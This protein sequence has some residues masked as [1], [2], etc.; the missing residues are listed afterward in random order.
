MMKR[1]LFSIALL[2]LFFSF[3]KAQT[4]VQIG[5][6]TESSSMPYT[7][8]SY[9]WAK[10]LYSGDEL[11]GTKTI[12]KI[13]LESGS[14]KTLDNQ[15]IYLKTTTDNALTGTYEDP[16]AN[17]TLVYSGSYSVT[18]GWNEITLDTPFEY[19]GSENLVVYWINEAGSEVYADFKAT[20][21]TEQVIKVKGGDASVPASD[22]FTAYPQ[23]LPN[24]RFHYQSDAPANPGNPQPASNAIKVDVETDLTFDLGNNTTHYDIC[25]GRD[26][27]NLDTIVDNQAATAPT[28]ITH[29]IDTLLKGDTE[30]F[31][32]AIAIKESTGER[33]ASAVW[34]FTTEAAIDQYP[35]S[36]SF[37]EVWEGIGGN[38]LSSII[39]TNYPD[40]TYWDWTEL[41]WN[42]EIDSNNVDGNIH[43]GNFGLH[44]SATS[45]GE[46]FVRTPRFILP[47]NMRVSFW[48]KNSIRNTKTAQN[49]ETYF[50][51]S[52]D[53]G[54]TWNTLDTLAPE[55]TMDTWENALVDLSDYAGNN[56]YLRWVYDVTQTSGNYVF[57]DDVTL[58]EKPEGAVIELEE[59]EHAYQQLCKGGKLDYE[60]VIYNSGISNLDI[61]DANVTGDFEC[62][63]S[64][65]IAAGEKDTAIV[66]F[67]PATSGDHEGTVSF[68]SNGS[69][70]AE[71]ALT[72]TA[73]EPVADFF[74]AFDDSDNL[75]AA[76]NSINSPDGYT[77]GGGV[78]VVSFSGD[79]FS[80]PNAAKI[81]MSNDT[82]SPLLLITPGV[83]NYVENHLTFYA[84]KA[85]KYYDVDMQVGVMSN[86]YDPSTFIPKET[87]SLDTVFRK[88]TVT[89][90]PTTS[91]P[92]IAFK[93]N[94]NP[95]GSDDWTSL[96]ID[97]ISWE[98]DEPAAPLAAENISP[99]ND[100][101]GV[102][103]LNA[104]NLK[105][106]AGSGNTN[107]FK[108]FI[109][110]GSDNWDIVNGDTLAENINEYEITKE[111][112]YSTQY[113]WKVVPFNEV[114]D[115]EDCPVWDF[116]TMEDPMV[117]SFPWSEN[118]DDVENTSGYTMPHGW[119]NQ[120]MND[121]NTTWDLWTDNP[122]AG[123]E[124]SH[125][126]PNA[127]YMGLSLFNPEN[128]YLYSVPFRF[129]SHKE[130]KL[131]FWWASQVDPTTGQVYKERVKIFL[132]DNNVDSAM[133][134]E[135][136]NDS[137]S[138]DI[139]VKDSVIFSPEKSGRQFISFY[140][141]SDPIENYVV[142]IDDLEVTV[143]NTAPVINST[144][145]TAVVQGDE[146]SYA[147]EASDA[148]G[149]DIQIN[150]ESIPGW[151]TLTDNGDGT[152]TLSGEPSEVGTYDITLSSTDGESTYYQEFEITV[153]EKE[154]TGIDH[155]EDSAMSIY[156]NPTSGQIQVQIEDDQQ[157]KNQTIKVSDMTGK[158]VIKTKVEG[159]HTSIDLSDLE[160]GI[161]ILQIGSLKNRVTEKIIL[162]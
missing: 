162:K 133:T 52:A 31:W 57:L 7:S 77:S 92:Y 53:G 25:F 32:Q 38:V 151:L 155:W 61:T 104:L 136:F 34:N 71:I 65:S 119:S 28:T 35:W 139:Y 70:N 132:G 98:L 20:T 21:T 150:A 145:D 63:Y 6:G 102:D 93:H 19:N 16:S 26:E 43:S 99:A 109:G 137:I 75:P 135:L 76:W 146:Y 18:S 142:T 1:L 95:N 36:T 29:T 156:P 120:D 149:D 72:G 134:T 130:Y 161:Y 60:L 2:A 108:L 66:S 13:S 45:E 124:Y 74:Q 87:I 85:D 147:I 125:S 89:F 81:L 86:P 83:K 49:D 115:A 9:S 157:H 39:N 154:S 17:Y 152:A 96:R 3:S 4:Y 33:Q 113:F 5:E 73:V 112:K 159:T 110:S 129:E 56:V 158:V 48:W 88:D 128:D 78:D 79:Y 59:T 106:S 148:D 94:G 122:E 40:S 55:S 118:F 143:T 22:G 116:T 131:S 69:G 15:K 111:L 8:W 121:D 127:M 140:A 114:G 144:P 30:Y 50:Q 23:A 103:I 27:N 64:G 97:N 58:E 68:N 126:A 44:C 117:T 37:E 11:G 101:M 141:W 14:A 62:N 47:E 46:S 24:I 12:T 84:K 41:S 10:A 54:Q 42:L 80:A 67:V 100:S 153:S 107:G 82:V 51:V 105:W 138:D 123:A 91:E 90:K 160:P